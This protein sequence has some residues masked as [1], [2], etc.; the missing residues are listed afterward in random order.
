MKKMI[1]G[2]LCAGFVMLISSAAFASIV[3]NS[4]EYSAAW[5]RSLARIGSVDSADAAVYNPAGT[6]KLKDGLYVSVSNQSMFK[7]YT[8]SAMGT[9]YT[10]DNAG[11][12]LP[13][14]FALYSSGDWSAYLALTIPAGGGSLE[15]EKGSVL[16]A[17]T[18]LSTAKTEMM[19]VYYG[20]TMGGAYAINDMVSVSLGLRVIYGSNTAEVAGG[21]LD[22]E[23]SAAGAGG[24]IGL[25]VTPI[26]DLNIG[27]RYE[28][29]T[30]LEW[31]ADKNTGAMKDSFTT[32][33]ET[34]DHDLPGLLSIGASYMVLPELKVSSDFSYCFI[35]NAD[36]DG[37]EKAYDNGYEISI[38]V[39]YA[40]MEMLK[41]S[42]GYQWVDQGEDKDNYFP[43]SAKLQYHQL[44]FGFQVLP[45][46]NLKIDFGVYR[47]FFQTD[48]STSGIEC[49]KSLWNVAIG[50]E[51][52]I[53]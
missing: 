14:I 21:G 32:E 24:I 40:V 5:V 41:A 19:S 9:D 13:S 28:T 25:N 18:P 52:K 26:K 12:L 1:S 10:A 47:T 44:G 29:R 16:T 42:I 36:W 37:D 34:S 11:L 48:T 51:Y 38:G 45:M 43:L 33:G 15:F 35:K 17:G 50:A 6:V 39:E 8:H 22:Y 7:E 2:L 31:K 23:E 46:E 53:F 49:E 20:L 3:D 30:W 4:T 27:M